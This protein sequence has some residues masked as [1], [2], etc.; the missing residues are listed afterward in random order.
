MT[1]YKLNRTKKV[2]ILPKNFN[3]EHLRKFALVYDALIEE[4]NIEYVPTEF[5]KQISNNNISSGVVRMNILGNINSDMAWAGYVG[6]N[7]PNWSTDFHNAHYILLKLIRTSWKDGF[8]KNDMISL[9]D[10]YNKLK[11]NRPLDIIYGVDYANVNDCAKITQMSTLYES[12]L[13]SRSTMI[14]ALGIT[15]AQNLIDVYDSTKLKYIDYLDIIHPIHK[16]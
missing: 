7:W 6:D 14:K 8:T 15:D 10:I 9:N 16:K 2:F 11:K 12:G 4:N 3:L 13:L 5:L 1:E